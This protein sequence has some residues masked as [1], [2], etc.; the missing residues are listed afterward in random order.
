M[1][2]FYLFI[3]QL[4]FLLA[5]DAQKNQGKRIYLPKG[6]DKGCMFMAGSAYQPGDTLVIRAASNPWDYIYLGGIKGTQERPVV[7]INE[8]TVEMK[9]GISLENCQYIK[10]TGSGSREKFGFRILSSPQVAVV[11]NG[12]SAHIEVERFFV[13]DCMFGCWIKNEADCDTSINS[14]VLDDMRI[15][16]F[17]MHHIN[18]EGFY[19][20]STD[21]NNFTRPKDCNGV[22]QYYKPSKLGNIKVYN[23]VI[24]GTGRPAIMLSN[25]QIGMSEIYNNKV[26][27]V[28]RE[29]NDQQGTGI[30]IG[31]YTR[32][33]VHH[34]TVKNTYTW[35]IASLGGSG[36]LRIE[37]NEVDSSGFL[38]GKSLN[39][40]QNI[41]IDT[42]P[43]MPV[44]STSFILKNNQ[45][46]HPGRDVR[47]IEVYST[48]KTY[49]VNNFICNNTS[50]GKPA[51]ITVAKGVRW[52]NC[53]GQVQLQ[54]S[55][56]PNQIKYFIAIGMA[57]VLLMVSFFYRKYKL[58]QNK[59]MQTITMA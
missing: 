51:G 15:H 46:S 42:R 35:G 24:D 33:Y 7:V 28:G 8:G 3:F 30:S 52:K 9:K 38:D 47:N 18:I 40:P 31:G 45:V 2:K 56:F 57:A 12:K 6:V 19:M 13:K 25:A 14:W 59:Q 20:G 37:N 32:A 29:Y 10:V 4:I 5:A 1:H 22:Q 26:S 49:A 34:N 54:T 41:M 17:E 36:L 21:P 58:K 11:I 48:Q 44:D 50:K 55:V 53:K 27:N 16:D 23:G 39:W 43:T